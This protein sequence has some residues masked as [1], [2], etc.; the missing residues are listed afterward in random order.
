M[1]SVICHDEQFFFQGASSNSE[2]LRFC[3]TSLCN[4]S[5]KNR[6]TFST[7]QIQNLNKSCPLAFSR[8]LNI[9][10]VFNLSS[11]WL[12]LLMFSRA[13]NS[14]RGFLSFVELASFARALGYFNLTISPIGSLS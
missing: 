5:R 1:A 13:L 9:S 11:D 8:A 3:F 4:W 14:R 10:R 2:L 6:A 7:N 12:A